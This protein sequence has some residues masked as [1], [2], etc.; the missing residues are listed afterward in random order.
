MSK[1]ILISQSELPSSTIGSWTTLYKNY[2]EGNHCIDYLICPEPNEKF[3]SVTYQFTSNSF[4]DKIASKI[5]KKSHYV[6]LKS[7]KKIISKDE[8]YVIQVVDNFKIVPDIAALL[9]KMDLQKNCKIQFFYH[10]FPPFLDNVKGEK[11]F[12]EIDEMVLL[13]QD[14][15]QAHLAFYSSLPCKFSVL[16]NGIDTNK[17]Y[18]LET[19]EKQKLKASLGITGDK[20]F[21]W[22]SQD[23]PKKGLDI[24]LKLWRKIPNNNNTLLV[25]GSDRKDIIP[26]VYFLGKIPNSDLPNFYQV[27]DVYLFPTLCQEGFP[28]SLTEALN[29]G[30]YCIASELGGVSEVL[31]GGK[32]GKLIKNPHFISEW[33]LAVQEFLTLSSNPYKLPK[34]LYSFENWRTGM[35]QITNEAKIF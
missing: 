5:Y 10:S 19:A 35:N 4:I 9:K 18:P 13:T 34:D 22:C 2:F 29:C 6:A 15:Y 7:L 23:R 16:P 26:G 28:L 25:I 3:D 17:F 20:V 21:L 31:Q 33:E 27:S 24:V 32:L 11:F 14:S 12:S 1:V 8:N 30:C